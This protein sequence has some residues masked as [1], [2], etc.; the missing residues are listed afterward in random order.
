MNP[1]PA[2]EGI[3]PEAPSD[4]SPSTRSKRRTRRLSII[5]ALA[6]ILIAGAVLVGIK[7]TGARSGAIN[8][9][10]ISCLYPA[11][12]GAHAEN[13]LRW[14][15]TTDTTGGDFFVRYT[16]STVAPLKW[17]GHHVPGWAAAT[18]FTT[19]S[20]YP[21]AHVKSLD[22]LAHTAWQFDITYK[23]PGATTYAAYGG[24]TC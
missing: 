4:A 22:G 10:S 17:N 12:T 9:S 15:D 8:I 16:N 21:T 14:N 7:S 1:T 18:M 11:S 3:A 6:L 23:A 2:D 20:G 19:D 13:E 24:R 5:G